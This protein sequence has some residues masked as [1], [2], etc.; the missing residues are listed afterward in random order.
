M[1]KIEFK[2]LRPGGRVEIFFV[3]DIYLDCDEFSEDERKSTAIYETQREKVLQRLEEFALKK[4]EKISDI[5]LVRVST[6]VKSVGNLEKRF[7]NIKSAITEKFGSDFCEK[8]KWHYSSEWRFPSSEM[9][10][11]MFLIK[12]NEKKTR[13]RN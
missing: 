7:D 1:N 4:N 3:T 2:H 11:L 6:E 9:V 5:Y 13:R 8:V 12:M 10:Q